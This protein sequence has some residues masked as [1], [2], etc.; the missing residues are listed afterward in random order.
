MNQDPS[1]IERT[2]HRLDE[3][4]TTCT[5]VFCQFTNSLFR[6]V[7]A[8]HAAV[9]SVSPSWSFPQK[10]SRSLRTGTKMDQDGPSVASICAPAFLGAVGS[11]GAVT[12]FVNDYRKRIREGLVASAAMHIRED[13]Q[14]NLWRRWTHKKGSSAIWL[15]YIY[16]DKS[17]A[18]ETFRSCSDLRSCPPVAAILHRFDDSLAN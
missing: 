11:S 9:R 10:S 8:A 7:R 5:D 14:R 13:Y 16:R 2:C 4:G 1:H 6:S 3:A 17:Q 12:V 15:H 18:S